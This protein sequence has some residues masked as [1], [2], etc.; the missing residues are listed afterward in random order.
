MNLCIDIGNS[1]IKIAVI[2]NDQVLFKDVVTKLYVSKIKKIRSEYSFEKVGVTASGKLP[3]RMIHHLQKN[4]HLFILND[5]AKLPIDIKYK[6]PKTLGRDRIAG[7]V[8]AQVLF[9]NQNNCVIDIGTCITYDVILQ[10]KEYIGGNIAPGVELRLRSMNDYT[11]ALP[12]VS[13]GG[14]EGLLGLSTEEALQNGA[15]IGT[16]LEIESFIE[17]IKNSYEEINVTLTGGDADFFAEKINSEIF[18]N[19][20]LVLIGLNEIMNFNG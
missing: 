19:R 1:L 20:N 15:T 10:N 12:L 6:T 7:V 11:A 8:G 4:Y 5:S 3:Q 13:R 17:R 9:P 16:L 14:L 2:D 18:V